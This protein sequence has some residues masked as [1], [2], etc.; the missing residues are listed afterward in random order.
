MS[1]L[2]FALRDLSLQIPDPR[3]AGG[4][5]CLSGT[6]IELSRRS[7]SSLARH[8]AL[9]FSVLVHCPAPEFVRCDHHNAKDACGDCE[10]RSRPVNEPGPSLMRNRAFWGDRVHQAR[11]SGFD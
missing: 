1:T 10:L 3:I 9:R 2:A 5:F 7:R 4:W 11:F 8:G 6:V